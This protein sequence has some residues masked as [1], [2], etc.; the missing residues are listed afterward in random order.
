[1]E[2][3]ATAPTDDDV[4]MQEDE[5]ALVAEARRT[6]ANTTRPVPTDDTMTTTAL[7]DARPTTTT[8]MEQLTTLAGLTRPQI[9]HFGRRR[10]ICRGDG[11]C[12]TACL[13]RA[14]QRDRQWAH[15]APERAAHV[16]R[17]SAAGRGRRLLNNWGFIR[18]VAIRLVRCTSFNSTIAE[19]D[20]TTRVR[21]R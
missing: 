19:E 4:V 17:V 9:R 5:E 20:Q 1:M 7:D 3:H 18:G 15:D 11:A 21:K 2:A 13:L 10:R 6:N 8:Q 14:E 12:C 16:R